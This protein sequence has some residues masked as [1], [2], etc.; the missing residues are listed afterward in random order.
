MNSHLIKLNHFYKEELLVMLNKEPSLRLFFISDLLTYGFEH[1]FCEFYGIIRNGV[2]K[3][4]IMVFR[5]SIHLTG[6]YLDEEDQQYFYQLVKDKNIEVIHTSE[7]FI[8]VLMG[9]SESLKLE[10]S[11]LS[12][13]REAYDPLLNDGDVEKLKEP[14]Y[15]EALT[16]TNS[17]F[18][19]D[20]SYDVFYENHQQG[21]S[22]TYCI[23]KNGLIV[24]LATVTALTM[25]SG[26]VVA[27]GTEER[28][29][30]RGYARRCVQTL[31]NDMVNQGREMVLFYSNPAA[32][33]MY[34]DIGF[35]DQQPYYMAQRLIAIQ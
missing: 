10:I 24:S 4:C 17:I 26:M 19:V 34:H 16:L 3:V 29:R 21:H 30:R 35:V 5:D 12:V 18:N 25:Q 6:D 23:K 31:C 27:V 33:K 2:I 15:K 9:F 28:Y 1:D 13:Y 32:G 14:D 7:N 20:E 11:Q 8:E 22:I